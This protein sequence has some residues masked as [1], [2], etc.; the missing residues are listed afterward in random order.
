MA[1]ENRILMKQAREALTN[2]WGLAILTYLIV[3]II[4]SIGGPV[5]FIIA[6]PMSLGSAI[7]TL[8]LSRG[9]KVE[10]EQI[11]DGFKKFEKAL[12]AY[13]LII[14]F[15]FLWS[16]LLIIPGIVAAIAYSQTFFLLADNPDLSGREAIA[17]STIL[18]QGKKWKYFCLILRFTGWFLL[19]LITFGIGFL[20]LTPYMQVSF[21]KFYDDI[22]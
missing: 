9:K 22:K 13:L 15:I 16:L 21:A 7:F 19:S 5:G 11:F 8:N 10:F 18:M 4:P 12:V 1:T 20:F 3:G 17:K 2:K 6:A 14:V